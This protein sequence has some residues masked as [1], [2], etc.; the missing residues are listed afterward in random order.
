MLLN[1]LYFIINYNNWWCQSFLELTI[2]PYIQV[3]IRTTDEGGLFGG[4]FWFWYVFVW[5]APRYDFDIS[6][7]PYIQALIRTVERWCLDLGYF[8][9]LIFKHYLEQLMRGTFW[10]AFFKLICFA[11]YWCVARAW[12]TRKKS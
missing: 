12:G 4:L 11:I 2:N 8:K 6:S 1:L 9:S 5:R 7:I 10:G 3:L